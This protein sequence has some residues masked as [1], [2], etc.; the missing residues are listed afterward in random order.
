GWYNIDAYLKTDPNFIEGKLLVSVF[1]K[2]DN[3]P[4]VYLVVPS[5]KILVKGI[6]N[7]DGKYYF[8]YDENGSIVLP[9]NTQA[10]ILAF[11]NYSEQPRIGKLLFTTSQDLN[12]NVEFKEI[13]DIVSEI[14]SLNL[15]SFQ[16][17]QEKIS[18][19]KKYLINELIYQFTC[20]TPVGI[21]ADSTMQTEYSY[22]TSA[23][24]FKT[25][26]I[27]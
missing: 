23:G 18:L 19:E 6:K 20:P 1:G 12:L 10:F 9:Q 15:D 13:K 8:F 25:S 24:G 2:S 21:H 17:V 26:V 27:K 14:K 5:K 11:D 3:D 22:D 7:K 16:V 4:Q